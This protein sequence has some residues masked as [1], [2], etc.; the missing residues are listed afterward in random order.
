MY[1]FLAS[2]SSLSSYLF[3]SSTYAKCACIAELH[4]LV[5]FVLSLPWAHNQLKHTL[6]SKT[7]CN[8]LGS[9]V[10]GHGYGSQPVTSLIEHQGLPNWF[11]VPID[12]Y[13]GT[14]IP[15]VL[16]AKRPQTTGHRE[17]STPGKILHVF[18]IC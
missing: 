4:V 15:H 9:Q 6:S 13:R 11:A 14:L 18:K 2:I 10:I 8:R 12:R 7:P 16:F 3:V 1:E 5:T 17:P